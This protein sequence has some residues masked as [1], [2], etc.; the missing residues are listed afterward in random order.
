MCGEAIGSAGGHTL[1]RVAQGGR[2]LM[3]TKFIDGKY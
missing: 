1:A 2:R 3:S